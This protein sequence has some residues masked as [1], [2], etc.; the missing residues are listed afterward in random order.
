MDASVSSFSR[1]RQS[2][3][4]C[5]HSLI[6]LAIVAGFLG[7]QVDVE[8]ATAQDVKKVDD[9]AAQTQWNDL[10]SDNENVAAAAMAQLAKTPDETLDLIERRLATVLTITP[11]RIQELVQALDNNS[12]DDREAA[13]RELESM[14]VLAL[15]ELRR[16][17]KPNMPPEIEARV[18]LLL[19]RRV[20]SFAISDDE[21]RMAQL[22][23]LLKKLDTPRGAAILKVI[24]PAVELQVVDVRIL[25]LYLRLQS[26]DPEV[27][28][29]AAMRLIELGKPGL[30]TLPN[31]LPLLNEERTRAVFGSVNNTISGHIE[32][33]LPNFG[34]DVVDPLCE[35]LAN[36]ELAMR[37]RIAH[38]LGTIRDERAIEPLFVAMR[39]Q[40]QPLHIAAREAL[41]LFE[42]KALDGFLKALDEEQ[43]DVRVQAIAGLGVVRDTR[44]AEPLV[45]LLGGDNKLL[46]DW[47]VDSLRNYDPAQ[48][49]DAYVK[50]LASDNVVFKTDGKIRAS[51]IHGLGRPAE[52]A[53]VDL[54]LRE[55]ASALDEVRSA[56]IY[57][58]SHAWGT[59][60]SEQQLAERFLSAL[61]DPARGV[62]GSAAQGLSTMIDHGALERSDR[63]LEGLI[64][65][66]GDPDNSV[67]HTTVQTLERWR[68]RRAVT[69]LLPLLDH[70]PLRDVTARALGEIGDPRAIAA[71]R[72]LL[73]DKDPGVVL[74][75]GMLKDQ[76]SFEAIVSL[77]GEKD[78][79]LR[80]AAATAL[81][82]LGDR[83]AVASLIPLLQLD[84]QTL[85]C[86]ATALGELQDPGAA[87]PLIEA[88]GPGL[89]RFERHQFHD[90][91]PRFSGPEMDPVARP[92]QSIGPAVIEP[93]ARSLD[94]PVDR[95]REV[96]T[97]VIYV[98]ASYD[99]ADEEEVRPAIEPLAIALADSSS[100]VRTNA[101]LTLA[102]LK[103]P[104]AT[105]ALV[106]LIKTADKQAWMYQNI[107]GTL[108][109]TNSPDSFAVLAPLLKEPQPSIRAAAACQLLRSKDPRAVP[110]VAEAMG[111]SSAEV[112]ERVA[113][114]LGNAKPTH[115]R[116]SLERLLKD[117]DGTV[118]AAAAKGLSRL[119]DV[120]SADALTTVLQDDDMVARAAA[121]IAL[122]QLGDPRGEPA[123]LR[124]L[125]DPSAPRRQQALMAVYSSPIK[126]GETPLAVAAAFADRT[127][128]VQYAGAM[129]L[130]A[131]GTDAAVDALSAQITDLDNAR[132]IVGALGHTKN[133]RALPAL[134]KIVECDDLRL[135]VAAVQYIATFQ[136]EAPVDAL[137]QLL[138]NPTP[139][140]RLAAARGLFSAKSP[141]AIPQLTAA[142]KDEDP[143]VREQATRALRRTPK[144]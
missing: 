127:Q 65:L 70:K 83:R 30:V 103:D 14:S 37:P 142:L 85:R 63:L 96:A 101:A 100:V 81:G 108:G 72:P 47:T 126:T 43:I 129:A 59:A 55:S 143:R 25:P 80:C 40:D 31:I 131:I 66:L 88:A 53:D 111:D 41:V 8:R 94:S 61:T 99:G 18:K 95:A 33:T 140:V 36:P 26:V 115:A 4:V 119:G 121:A 73:P 91:D 6:L 58:L 93:L 3:F 32:Q 89:G 56:S 51:I 104:R 76:Q 48:V 45:K 107:I 69:P 38:L 34:P 11:A 105:P 120:Q 106:D 138:S 60:T 22:V 79:R 1:T 54:L 44:A 74:A 46:R 84:D 13:Q 16:A 98:L 92:L 114:A 117:R 86:A 42:A 23:P 118:R 49:R 87:F 7:L 75:L 97:Y 50:A 71:L 9:E 39:D 17:L 27:R 67:R 102:H 15:P 64:S 134:L 125:K 29:E 10:A 130:G 124:C 35:A 57:Q 68:D 136:G 21:R 12:F 137:A 52:P 123:F 5:A 122:V 19:T 78:E 20:G 62:R 144:P 113:D 133:A 2:S 28:L 128:K 24:E 139:E 109:A 112:R 110:L 82:H 116:G 132:T 135:R 141:R 77:L 90:N